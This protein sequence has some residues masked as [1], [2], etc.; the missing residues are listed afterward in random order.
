MSSRSIISG[1]PIGL[2][3]FLT[4]FTKR[5]L[6]LVPHSKSC[7]WGSKTSPPYMMTGG[8]WVPTKERCASNGFVTI[9]QD[10]HS[11]KSRSVFSALEVSTNINQV[12]EVCAD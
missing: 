2:S 5:L 4:A 1:R 9:R 12:K 7:R 3:K 6:V 11:C 10:F 8:N